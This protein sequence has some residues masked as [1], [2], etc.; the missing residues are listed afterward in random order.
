M[1]NSERVSKVS[2]HAGME[3]IRK[4]FKILIPSQIIC[5][6][7]RQLL[8]NLAASKVTILPVAISNAEVVYP[9]LST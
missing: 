2:W 4:I 1:Y 9:L 8:F 7:F 6:Q 3:S 5:H